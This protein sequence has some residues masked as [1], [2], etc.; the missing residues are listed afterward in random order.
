M[1]KMKETVVLNK[2]RTRHRQWFELKEK[3]HESETKSAMHPQSQQHAV[4]YIH[5]RHRLLC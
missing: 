4:E 1:V 2:L 3:D 5:C